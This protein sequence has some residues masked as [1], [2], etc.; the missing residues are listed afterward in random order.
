VRNTYTKAAGE[1]NAQVNNCNDDRKKQE[2]KENYIMG[3][4][5]IFTL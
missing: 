1:R 4:F 2:D 5:V 3:S